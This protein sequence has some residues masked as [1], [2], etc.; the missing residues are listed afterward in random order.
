MRSD[1]PLFSRREGTTKKKIGTPDR[2]L[3][4]FNLHSVCSVLLVNL[5]TNVQE[6]LSELPTKLAM[7]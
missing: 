2:R 7:T 1:V 4:M 5:G 6:R 3:I